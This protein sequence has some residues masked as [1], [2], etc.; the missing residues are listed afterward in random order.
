MVIDTDP[1]TPPCD[2]NIQQDTLP[3]VGGPPG[4]QEETGRW[5]LGGCPAGKFGGD[6]K[7]FR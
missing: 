2:P 6:L 7:A 1:D 3:S 4:P 5:M